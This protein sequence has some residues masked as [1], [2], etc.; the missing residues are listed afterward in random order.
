MFLKDAV[1]DY[2]LYLAH[3]QNASVQT[4]RCYRNALRR[5]SDWLRDNGHP[6]ATLADITPPVA[7]R[8]LYHLNESGLRP[9][10][11]LRLWTPIRSLFRML[12]DLQVVEHSPVEKIALPKKD[13]PQRLLVSDEELQQVLAAAGRQ[14][15]P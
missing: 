11:R 7:R 2:L 3:E 15:I 12:I 13:P 4:V 9:R 10:T 5:F 1:Q 8:Y 14:R 6:A